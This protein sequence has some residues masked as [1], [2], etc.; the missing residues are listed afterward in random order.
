MGP[1]RSFSPHP[2]RVAGAVVALSAGLWAGSAG[3]AVQGAMGATSTGRIALSMT[4]APTLQLTGSRDVILSG[5][6]AWSD[7]QQVCVSG[8]GLAGY[9]LTVQG[10][11]PVARL[12]LDGKPVDRAPLHAA[13]EGTSCSD[14]GAALLSMAGSGQPAN[15][16][17]VL[18]V[19]P[20]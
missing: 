19:S 9:R 7:Q 1:D 10:A 6:G 14:G 3:A 2:V 11:A 5:T 20:E 18:L 17:L 8:V 4:K 16:P 13:A 15:A 12:E